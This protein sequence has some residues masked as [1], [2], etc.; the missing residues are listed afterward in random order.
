MSQRI[1]PYIRVPAGTN[2][3]QLIT[4]ASTV[5]VM[6]LRWAQYT[7]GTLSAN[8]RFALYDS[9]NTGAPTNLIWAGFIA[10][11]TQTPILNTILQNGLV[12]AP[13]AALP[14]DILIYYGA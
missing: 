11:G 14:A 8:A 13:G 5:P 10:P 6:T 4:I 9:T 1:F 3:N 12:F 2:T 7:D